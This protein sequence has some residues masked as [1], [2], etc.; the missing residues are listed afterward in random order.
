[1]DTLFS[2][3]LIVR[4]TTVSTT[5][6]KTKV[7]EEHQSVTASMEL[8]NFRSNTSA[9]ENYFIVFVIPTHPR[10]VQQ[11]NV[12]RK[13]WANV[14]KWSL[15]A[16]Q[17]EEKKKIKVLFVCGNLTKEDS[18]DEFKALKKKCPIMKTYLFSKT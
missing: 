1:M 14:E 12:I 2:N 17:D 18:T 11:R 15:L 10:K 8:S 5:F 16:E 4:T 6:L 13:T 9:K 3:T 7:P